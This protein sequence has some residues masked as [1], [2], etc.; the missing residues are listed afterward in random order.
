MVTELE[1]RCQNIFTGKFQHPIK[2]E[3]I[4]ATEDAVNV[5]SLAVIE[6]MTFI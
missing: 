1:K 4:L 6:I 3:I 5:D 2:L